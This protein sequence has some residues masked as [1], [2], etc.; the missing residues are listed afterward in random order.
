MFSGIEI[1]IKIRETFLYCRKYQHFKSLFQCYVVKFT[2][3]YHQHKGNW[4][5]QIPFYYCLALYGSN[6]LLENIKNKNKEQ[7]MCTFLYNQHNNLSVHLLFST[8]ENQIIS[9]S[10]CFFKQYLHPYENANRNMHLCNSYFHYAKKKAHCILIHKGM[11]KNGSN[12][13]LESLG[14]GMQKR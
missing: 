11:Q 14:K 4:Q 10:K 1:R 9:I 12:R 5:G 3:C 6:C 7:H 2:I 8:K 13:K